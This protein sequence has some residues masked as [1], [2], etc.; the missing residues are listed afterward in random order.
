MKKLLYRLFALRFRHC[1]DLVNAFGAGT[2]AKG[3]ITQIADAAQTVANL[4]V[5]TGSAAGYAAVTTA[6]TERPLGFAYTPCALGD[7][8][9]VDLLG[10]GGDTK[11]AVASGAITNDARLVAAAGGK[12]AL[13]SG[14]GSGTFYVIGRSIGAAADGEPIEVDDCHPYPVTQ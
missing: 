9:A 5:K 11:L 7:S 2:H 6:A 3:R 13:L 12:V 10:K 1:V 8:I 14:A 4:L